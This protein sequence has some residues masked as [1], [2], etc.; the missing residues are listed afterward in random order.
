MSI[1][2]IEANDILEVMDIINEAKQYFK[3][4]G[5]TQ[6]QFGYP[7]LDTIHN[8]LHKSQGYVLTDENGIIGYAA[9]VLED[10]PNYAVIDGKWLS[11]GHYGVIHRVCIRNQYKG[12]GYV[13]QFFTKLE[14]LASLQGFASVRVD[15][16]TLNTSMRKAIE[17]EGFTYCGIVIVD[18]GTERLAFEKMLRDKEQTTS[19]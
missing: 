6:W 18:D 17:K 10:D 12:K 8:D 1:R 15:T 19:M 11:D 4:S 14:E 5:S 13:H 16:H 7:N 2:L 3:A 9:L